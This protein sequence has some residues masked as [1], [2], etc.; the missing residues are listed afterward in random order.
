MRTLR[1]VVARIAGTFTRRHR[2]AELGDE[3]RVHL[4]MLA[5]E[6]ERRGLSP[7]EA[8]RAA[9]IAFGGV[10]QV[11]EAYREQRR[12][13]FLDTLAQDVRYA[14]RMW[15]RA[16]AFNVVVIL[17]LALGIGANSAM[18]TVVNALLFRPLPAVPPTSSG[19]TATT[20]RNRIPIDRF[21]IRITQTCA[22]EPTCSTR[23]SPTP[24]HW[25]VWRR[26][27]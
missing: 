3:L 6:Y 9:R 24:S 20:R 14:L 19:S 15:R 27:T 18:F 5:E 7:D 12:L 8:A 26:E 4:E 1:S 2:D 10:A 13:P 23:C 25:S 17:V 22:I 21:P 16:P 11:T